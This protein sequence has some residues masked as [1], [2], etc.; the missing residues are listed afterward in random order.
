MRRPRAFVDATHSAFYHNLLWGKMKSLQATTFADKVT[1]EIASLRKP[2]L[3]DYDV[4]GTDP[5]L[6]H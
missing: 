1:R 5:T 2:V 6:A 3:D 4:L